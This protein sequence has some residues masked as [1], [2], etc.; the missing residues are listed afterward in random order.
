MLIFGMMM[1]SLGS[2][3]PEV[4]HKFS[5]DELATGAL[6]T[7]L[8]GGVM[9]ASIVFG[10][11][12]DRFAYKSI[13]VS[14]T[15]LTILGIYGL[16]FS[17]TLIFLNMAVFLIGFGSGVLNGLTNSLVSEI[18][19]SDRSANLSFLGIFYG[20]GALGTPALFGFLQGLYSF[21]TIFFWLGSVL[22]IPL[23][24]FLVI[25]FPKSTDAKGVALRQVIKMLSDPLLLI[26]GFILFFQSGIEGIIANWTTTYLDNAKD[27]N[28]STA[29]FMLS[30]F[31]AALT[32]ARMMLTRILRVYS[33]I[34]VMIFSYYIA[35]AGC[36]LIVLTSS[37]ILI[38]TG[39]CFIGLGMACGFPVIL[40]YI[41]QIY[42]ELSGTAFSIVITIALIGNVIANYAMGLIS[43]QFGIDWLAH[44]IL[45]GMFAVLGLLL[46]TRSKYR[47]EIV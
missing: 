29:L 43:D 41:G 40:G 44:F 3:L 36:L 2:I 21:E 37:V 35:L 11:L 7:L 9:V 38:A 13:I 24:F 47:R 23:L 4:I 17:P 20:V 22:V 19:K 31:L 16:V 39:M 10:P 15:L 34:K 5:L 28:T 27:I 12:V 30:G 14:G 1:I 42:T 6:I 45:L 18:S 46:I 32:L 8:P 33:P 25:R 26:F